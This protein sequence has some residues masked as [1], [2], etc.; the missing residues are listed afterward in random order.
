VPSLQELITKEEE[1]ENSIKVKALERAKVEKIDTSERLT[2]EGDEFF[3][4]LQTFSMYKL[5]YYQCFKC[6]EAYFGGI[7]DCNEE[8]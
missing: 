7:K 5:S 2:T 4:N 1:F 3:E 6:N 8:A